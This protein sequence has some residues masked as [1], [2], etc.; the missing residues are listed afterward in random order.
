MVSCCNRIF[1]VGIEF[2]ALIFSV[3]S[4]R[5]L[6][7]LP[8]VLAKKRSRL[9]VFVFFSQVGFVLCFDFYG[10]TVVSLLGFLPP[11]STASVV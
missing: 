5:A 6:R 2:L 10:H 3:A 7:K 4:G 11:V 1:L 8:S 9:A